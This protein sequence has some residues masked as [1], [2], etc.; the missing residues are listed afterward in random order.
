M[1]C[2]VLGVEKLGAVGVLFEGKSDYDKAPPMCGVLF[3]A[4]AAS[5]GETRFSAM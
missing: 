3:C 5:P 4:Y 2:T 1:R